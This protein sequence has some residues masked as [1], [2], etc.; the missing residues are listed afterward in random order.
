M[1]PST[2]CESCMHMSGID[3]DGLASCSWFAS[4]PV[5]SHIRLVEDVWRLLSTCQVQIRVGDLQWTLN[6]NW[7]HVAIA[8][9]RRHSAWGMRNWSAKI[10][11]DCGHTWMGSWDFGPKTS[12][13][14]LLVTPIPLTK[15]HS[16]TWEMVL[17]SQLSSSRRW[18]RHHSS[19]LVPVTGMRAFSVRQWGQ[20]HWDRYL[21]HA[22]STLYDSG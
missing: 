22:S 4:C 15:I 8:L 11:Q 20:G 1:K 12:W 7:N 16:C 18:L 14:H 21:I 19:A 13:I 10:R 3:S 5:P 2:S 17:Q 9:S 6:K